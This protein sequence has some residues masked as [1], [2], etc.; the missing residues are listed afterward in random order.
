MTTT[1]LK[2]QLPDPKDC[3]PKQLRYLMAEVERNPK[4]PY[5]NKADP[6]HHFAVEWMEAAY[7]TLHPEPE[8][9][10]TEVVHIGGKED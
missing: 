8:D 5:F 10:L 6:L 1:Q 7:Q 9:E 3:T 2:D 4:H